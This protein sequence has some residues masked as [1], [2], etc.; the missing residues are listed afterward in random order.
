MTTTGGQPG[1]GDV[2]AGVGENEAEE[3]KGESSWKVTLLEVT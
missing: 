3:K 2:A 1:R